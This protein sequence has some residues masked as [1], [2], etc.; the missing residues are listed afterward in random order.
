MGICRDVRE[1]VL[2]VL[3][4]R[5]TA[6]VFQGSPL[7]RGAKRVKATLRQKSR[8][9]TEILVTIG[10]LNYREREYVRQCRKA[11]CAPRRIWLP[12]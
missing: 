3:S 7:M 9:S 6:V 4:G 1:A 2:A 10:P 11:K 8:R 12:K 5:K